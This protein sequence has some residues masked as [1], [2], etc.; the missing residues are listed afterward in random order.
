MRTSE[1]LLGE[2]RDGNFEYG[3]PKVYWGTRLTS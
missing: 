3:R 1:A 2:V